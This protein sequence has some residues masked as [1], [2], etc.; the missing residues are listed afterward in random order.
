MKA[1]LAMMRGS[2]LLLGALGRLL[3]K[4]TGQGFHAR[5]TRLGQFPRPNRHFWF[6]MVG[7]QREGMRERERER[8]REKN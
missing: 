5:S 8:E 7:V 6:L 1:G 3:C 2:S 4:E